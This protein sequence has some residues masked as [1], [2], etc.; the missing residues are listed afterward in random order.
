MSDADGLFDLPADAYLIPS[1]P[2]ELSR[3]ERR[4]RLIYTRIAN[5]EHPLGKGI[6]LHPD[7]AKDIGDNKDGLRCG[8]CRYRV[9]IRHHDK[10]Y[11]KC[12][13]PTTFGGKP[14]Y[15]RDTGCESSD[16]RAW[17]PACIDHQPETEAP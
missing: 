16:V 2:E 3:G 8:A 6:R 5:G 9:T 1:P 10:T 12:H 13:F 14:T 11:P 4:R 17:W 15:P 7:A